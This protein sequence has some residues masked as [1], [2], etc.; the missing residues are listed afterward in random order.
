V[1]TVP[2]IV[3]VV[4]EAADVACVATALAA[5]THFDT[6]RSRALALGARIACG[7]VWRDRDRSELDWAVEEGTG[8][9]VVVNGTVFG[10][11]PAARRIHARRL[12]DVYLTAG[13]LAPRELDGAFV[14]MIADPRKRSVTLYNDRVGTL[15]IYYAANGGTVC[16]APEAKAVFAALGTSPQ[17]SNAG[18]VSFLARGYC[19]GATTLFTGVSFLEPGSSLEISA[20]SGQVVVRRYWKMIYRPAREL[21]SRVA[22]ED[23][24]HAATQ[25]AHELII[26]DSERGYDLMLSGGWDSRGILAYLHSLGR[27]PRTAVA[28]GKTR[29]VPFSD[30]FLAS[31]LAKQFAIPLKFVSYDSDQFVGNA[32]TWCYLSELANDNTGWYAEGASTLARHYR[33]DADFTLVGDEAWGWHG[34]P[35]T[36]LDAVNATLPASPSAA[37]LACLASGVRDECRARYEGDVAAVLA[38]CESSHPADR[39]DFLYLHGRVARFI[40]ALGYYKELATEVR[41]PFLLGN[42]LDVLAEVPAGFRAEKNLYI[43]M[44]GRFFPSVA[45]VPPRSADSLPNWTADIR[46]K[47]ELRRFF[48]DLLDESSLGGALGAVLD[49]AAIE[50]LKRKFFDDRTGGSSPAARPNPLLGHLPLRMKQRLRATGFYP[51]STNMA[52]G[53]A[54]RGTATLVRNVALLSL[55]QRSLP[56][57]GAAGRRAPYAEELPRYD[58]L[59]RKHHGRANAGLVSEL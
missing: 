49:A 28:W 43:S 59:P 6:Y 46:E 52:G 1:C 12:L 11:G 17:L 22:A 32:A 34:H 53:Y 15:P 33:T 18:I 23:A 5:L 50:T 27:L 7:Q 58:E 54:S 9:A 51:G 40:F 42:V 41:R 36:N 20:A 45:S 13:S 10:T 8:V 2:G 38:A 25:R 24:L 26:G 48:L 39:R 35:R 3:G 47:P 56:A 21:R 29:D 57:F 44:I 14:I 37:V 31:Q 30:P 16:F 55:L 4:G 19:I